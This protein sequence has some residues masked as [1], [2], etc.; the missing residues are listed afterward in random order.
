MDFT[1]EWSFSEKCE[2]C[3]YTAIMKKSMIQNNNVKN[4]KNVKNVWML[5]IISCYFNDNSV[6]LFIIRILFNEYSKNVNINILFQLT[7]RNS[8]LF[9]FIYNYINYLNNFLINNDQMMNIGI[10]W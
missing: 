8:Y 1:H 6:A 5:R 10:F 4:V 7:I 9:R 2:K 3:N